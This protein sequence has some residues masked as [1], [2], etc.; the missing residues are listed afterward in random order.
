MTPLQK[1]DVVF[2]YLGGVRYRGRFVAADGAVLGFRADVQRGDH[3][4]RFLEDEEGLTWCRGK[5]ADWRAML[6]ARALSTEP[7]EGAPWTAGL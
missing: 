3:A 6:A 2:F 1:G 5:Y 4:H 7:P